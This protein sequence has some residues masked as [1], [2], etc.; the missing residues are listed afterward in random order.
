MPNPVLID[1]SSAADTGE[2]ASTH[3]RPK[4]LTVA[5]TGMHFDVI[6]VMLD[7]HIAQSCH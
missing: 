7:N 2:L 5:R 6:S 1:G 3:G 4:Y